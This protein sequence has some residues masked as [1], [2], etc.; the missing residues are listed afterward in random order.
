MSGK[1]EDLYRRWILDC[2]VDSVEAISKDFVQHPQQYRGAT[3]SGLLEEFKAR[4]GNDPLWPNK[5]QRAAIYGTLF[6]MADGDSDGENSGQ[7][8]EAASD[9]RRRATLYA[10]RV[11]SSGEEMLRQA[12]RDSIE[13]FQA[14]L[15]TLKGP[16]VDRGD[17]Q[18]T[19]IFDKA[20]AVL[21][22]AGVAQR[23]G[24]LPPAP[25]NW[26]TSRPYGGD[27]ANLIE[28]IKRTLFVGPEYQLP[29]KRFLVMQRIATYGHGTIADV[30]SYKY[31][32]SKGQKSTTDLIT[33][34]YSWATAILDSKRM[35]SNDGMH[36]GGDGSKPLEN[37][38]TLES[39]RNIGRNR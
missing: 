37:L 20:V 16:V 9:V 38:S 1:L 22:D 35:N 32:Q 14:Y 27:G 36:L 10:E 26:P 3:T 19:N 34:A 23:F 7:F 21:Q 13:T 33:A 24:G 31:D 30:Q 5:E 12:F 6:G 29:R 17:A 8:G 39:R 28:E 15:E 2:V 18:T 11:F 4:T 25:A